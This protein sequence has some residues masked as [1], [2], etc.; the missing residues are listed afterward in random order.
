MILTRSGPRTVTSILGFEVDETFPYHLEYREGDHVFRFQAELTNLQ[1]RADTMV[2]DTT[3][4]GHWQPPF[5]QEPLDEATRHRILVRV[6]AALALLNIT[7]AWEVFAPD[8]R[9]RDWPVIE[10]E[11]AALLRRAEP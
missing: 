2:Y 5:E 6:S 4:D 10:A 1:S 7:P 3:K 8:D 11:A 9:R